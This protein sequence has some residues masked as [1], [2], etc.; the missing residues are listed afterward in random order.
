M[1]HHIEKGLKAGLFRYMDQTHQDQRIPGGA[2]L[3]TEI[4]ENKIGPRYYGSTNMKAMLLKRLK[5]AMSEY[6]AA[7]E[8]QLPL[9][10]PRL[11]RENYHQLLGRFFGYYAPLETQLLALPWRDEIAFMLVPA[12][13]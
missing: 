4:F 9:L 1:P 3:G 6:H 13:K 7:L 10:D 11:S 8:C 12:W 2:G 5:Q